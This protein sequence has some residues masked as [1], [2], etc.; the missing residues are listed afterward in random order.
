MSFNKPNIPTIQNHT[1]LL[2]HPPLRLILH[3]IAFD[4]LVVSSG[5]ALD[6]VLCSSQLAVHGLTSLVIHG[7]ASL[8][9]CGLSSHQ[10]R[11]ARR[12]QPRLALLSRLASLRTSLASPRSRPRTHPQ[13]SVCQIPGI[14]LNCSAE[15]FKCVVELEFSNF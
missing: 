5:L 12:P 9:V 2:P 8:D 11:R 15:I 6:I 14:W 4:L 10:S 1:S 3:F 13:R 7:L